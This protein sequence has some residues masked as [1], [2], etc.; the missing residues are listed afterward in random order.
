MFKGH[1][2]GAVEEP[3]L[4]AA[5]FSC[6]KTADNSDTKV[7][8]RA[9]LGRRNVSIVA[10]QQIYYRITSPGTWPRC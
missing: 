2:S 6:A 1:V 8:K 10:K 5:A 9:K 7:A 4:E 3:L